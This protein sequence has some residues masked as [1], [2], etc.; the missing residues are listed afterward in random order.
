MNNNIALVMMVKDEEPFILKTLKS[1]S[2]VIDIF[3]ILDTGSTDNTVSV[4]QKY[5][6]DN[7]K[8][9]YLYESPFVD[10]STS[11]NLLLSYCE[12]I[13]VQYLLLLDCSDCIQNITKNTFEN[14]TESGYFVT[15]KWKTDKSTLI[16]FKTIRII[17]NKCGWKY[18]GSVHEYIHNDKLNIDN[19][20]CYENLTVFQ[21]RSVEGGYEKSLKRFQR[22]K[23]LLL[24]EYNDSKTP[25]TTFYLGQTFQCLGQMEHALDMYKERIEFDDD[26]QEERYESCK[27]IGDI[28]KEVGR[29]DESNMYYLKSIEIQERVEPLLC[30]CEYYISKH[31]W[32]LAYTFLK[33]ACML[34]YPQDCVLSV[35]INDYDYKRWHMLG[36]VAFY[37]DQFEEGRES[38]KK[39]IEAGMNVDIDKHNLTFYDKK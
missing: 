24:K 16:H 7:N 9:L 37:V 5:C 4:I 34:P 32:W 10:F 8:I 14:L 15:Q 18:Y 12:K 36:M 25:R 26:F 11:R 20:K 1:V 17:Q 38:C 28:L 27:R 39:A 31:A 35:D 30:L 2:S 33:M 13:N 6:S 22:D 23:E 3:I 19:I 29:Y 21:D